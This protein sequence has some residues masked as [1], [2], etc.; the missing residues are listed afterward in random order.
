MDKDVRNPLLTFPLAVNHSDSISFRMPSSVYS[1]DLR[2]VL[3]RP[4]RLVLRLFSAD[5]HE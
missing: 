3:R 2:D 1:N 5:S 4:R